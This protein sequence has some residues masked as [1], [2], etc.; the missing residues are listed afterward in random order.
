V[1]RVTDLHVAEFT[2]EEPQGGRPLTLSSQY[3]RLLAVACDEV[4][5]LHLL[6]E[7][8]PDYVPG[9]FHGIAYHD[10]LVTSITRVSEGTRK[11]RGGRI[12]ITTV[13][14]I[15]VFWMEA[16][17]NLSHPYDSGIYWTRWTGEQWEA[18]LNMTP[19]AHVSNLSTNWWERHDSDRVRFDVVAQGNGEMLLV[20]VEYTSYDG[21]LEVFERRY[22]SVWGPEALV[23]E[24]TALC[25]GLDLETTPDGTAHLA[26]WTAEPPYH[27]EGSIYHRSFNGSEWS[28]QDTLDSSGRVGW[29]RMAVGADSLL[30][31]VWEG[32]SE[33]QIV[34]AWSRLT[35]DGW[36]D[37]EFLTV[38]AGSETW[39]PK[40]ACL[41]DGR[42]AV[43][44]SSRCNERA[45]LEA[46][47]L[48]SDTPV[49]TAFYATLVP[50]DDAV[51]LRWV[52]PSCSGGVGLMIYRAL[53]ADGPYSCITQEP[54][55]DTALG[56]YIDGTAW[57]GGTFWYELRAVLAS[58]EEILTTDMRPSIT[59]PGTLAFGIRYV[60]PNPTTAPATIGYTLPEG[61]RS[62]R[63]SVH[64][65]AGRLVRRL[66][67]ATGTHGFVTIDWDGTASS[68]ERVASGVYFVRLEVDGAV[69]T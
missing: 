14:E 52:L 15:H 28:E 47:I 56:S 10:S 30:Y 22:D 45:T 2:L 69:A 38:R 25:L 65:V 64:D 5:T 36:Q 16:G 9:V 55:P 43:V 39:Y 26:Y 41:S 60:M 46:A 67:P 34:P 4:G 50:E 49:E 1:S 40:P 48:S 6:W 68:G 44:W 12:V 35:G 17:G 11:V 33:G 19:G 66:D 3:S 27:V 7:G 29:P 51:L 23:T 54:L 20:W 58:G 63:L 53:S 24:E 13:G 62:A 21:G 31:L 37:P 42:V 18:S 32:E 59:V 61:W 57:P 8:K